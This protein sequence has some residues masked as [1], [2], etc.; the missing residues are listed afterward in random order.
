MS[1]RIAVMFGGG[2]ALGAFGCGA[3]RA[4]ASRLPAGTQVIGAAGASVGA[5]NAMFVAR[6]GHDYAGG[7]Q[8]MEASWR[9]D[10]ATPSLPFAGFPF[11]RL[12]QS[13]NGL[14]TGMLVGTRGM[15]HPNFAHWNPLAGLNRLQHPLMDRR[16]MWELLATRLGSLRTESEHDTLLAAAAVDVMSGK[17]KLFDSAQET[18]DVRHLCASGAI[19]LL[20]E[21]VTL[22]GRLYWDGDMTREAALPLF[23]DALRREGR[24]APQPAPAQATVL[25]TIDQ[26]TEPLSKPPASGIE[27]AYRAMDLLIHGKMNLAPE[28]LESFTHVVAIRRKPLEHDGISGQF[29]YSPERIGELIDQG[30]SQADEAWGLAGLDP[31]HESLQRYG[32]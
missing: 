29:D 30:M 23:I 7:A 19:P 1:V 20:Y 18:L 28:Q 25:V 2:G 8:A 15:G 13:W 10:M 5:V 6:H 27:V 32:T 4:I 17:L 3:W 16:R 12:V 21:P 31:L 26:M 9:H 24:L 11:S 22:D 14:L